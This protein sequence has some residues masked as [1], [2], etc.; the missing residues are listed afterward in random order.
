MQYSQKSIDN[1]ILCYAWFQAMFTRIDVVLLTEDLDKN[2]LSVAENIKIAIAGLDSMANRFNSDSELSKINN[3]AFEKPLP[4]SKEMHQIITECIQFHSKTLGYFD[5]TINSRNGL[6]E[7]ISQI[8]LQQESIQLLHPDVQLDLSGFIKGYALR[9]IK[10]ILFDANIENA[11]INM[12]NSSIFA[13]GNHPSGKGWKITSPNDSGAIDALLID[14][15]LTNSGNSKTTKWPIKQPKN[16][17]V[18]QNSTL[19]SVITDDPAVGEALSIALYLAKEEEKQ[20][21]LQQM[22]ENQINLN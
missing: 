16:G 11:L 5:I 12:G 8:E 19:I 13:K 20:I 2:L 15:C 21:I 7:A 3:F 10:K 6:S 1:K 18:E 4:I 14:Q 9:T 17:A 22:N